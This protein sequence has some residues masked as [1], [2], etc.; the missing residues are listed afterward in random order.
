MSAPADPMPS[1]HDDGAGPEGAAGC[2]VI[3]IVCI[4]LAIA[5]IL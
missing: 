4:A 1:R 5:L 3:A 2:L